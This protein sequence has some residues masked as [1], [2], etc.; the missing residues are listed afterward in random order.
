[1]PGT[2]DRIRN[3]GRSRPGESISTGTRPAYT[4]KDLPDPDAPTMYSSRSPAR[5]RATSASTSAL[6]PKNS[7]A[8]SL[9]NGRSPG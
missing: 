6:R 8:L 5:S 9:E 2:T 1:V 3:R 7:F 4:S